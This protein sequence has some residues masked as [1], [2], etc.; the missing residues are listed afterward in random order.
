MSESH[1]GC[2]IC[3]DCLSPCES[4]PHHDISYMH[5][6]SVYSGMGTAHIHR[7]YTSEEC[8]LLNVR[9]YVSSTDRCEP[10]AR[11]VSWGAGFT[12]DQ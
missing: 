8:V 6:K 2:C 10:G 5:S 7:N 4:E 9:T 11:S 1:A 3:L 12:F